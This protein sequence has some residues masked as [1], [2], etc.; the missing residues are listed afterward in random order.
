MVTSF[1]FTKDEIS[2]SEPGK[3]RRGGI[4]PR[5]EKETSKTDVPGM[6]IHLRNK[7]DMASYCTLERVFI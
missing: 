3:G 4:V 5:A 7:F 2:G 1:I 6:K